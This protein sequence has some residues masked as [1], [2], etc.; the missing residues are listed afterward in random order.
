MK[1]RWVRVAAA[2]DV[3]AGRS[4]R[5]AAEGRDL[6]LHNSDGRIHCTSNVCPH[7]GQAL[8]GGGIDGVLEGGRITCPWHAWVF[9]V[10][11]GVSPFNPWARVPCFP[12]KVDG[13]DV[14]VD[15]P[16]PEARG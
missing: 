11:T 1:Q 4:L 13:G 10:A 8:V 3:P 9:D 16:P 7:Q 15:L 5:V 6:A 12:V 14:Y 2:G